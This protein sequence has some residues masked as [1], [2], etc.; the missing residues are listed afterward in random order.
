MKN[1]FKNEKYY[2]VQPIS[3]S[4][5]LLDMADMLKNL[6]EPEIS[7]LTNPNIG[8]F[9][10][11][12]KLPFLENSFNLTPIPFI[13]YNLLQ[14]LELVSEKQELDLNSF[15]DLNNYYL[16]NLNPFEIPILFDSALDIE[17]GYCNPLYLGDN[18]KIKKLVFTEFII[19]SNF[20]ILTPGIYAHEVVHSQLEYNNSVDNYIHSEVLPIFFDKLTALYTDDNY[21][22]LNANERLR[23]I[24]LFKAITNCKNKDLSTL[25]INKLSMGITSILEAENLFDIYLYGTRNDKDAIISKVNDALLGNIQVEDLL[26][27]FDITTEN[28]QNKQLIKRHINNSVLMKGGNYV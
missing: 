3:L 7:R 23:F 14:K 22:T 6:K 4:S 15:I 19:N 12:G 16:N 9:L 20:S 11:K 25:E 21:E 28:C 18:Q 13:P 17:G 2:D 26:Q 10:Y 5:N 24:R 1:G 8:D 27:S